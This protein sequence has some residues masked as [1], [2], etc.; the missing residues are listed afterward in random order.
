MLRD[1]VKSDLCMQ[2][3][4]ELDSCGYVEPV[5]PRSDLTFAQK[6]EMIRNHRSHWEHSEKV[7]P[8]VFELGV[9][10]DSVI[11]K[12]AG[13]VYVQELP[14]ANLVG[15]TRGLNFNQLPSPNRGIEYKHWAIPDLGSDP[16]DFCIDPEQDLLVLLEAEQGHWYGGTY[17]LHLR[18]MSTNEVHP[19][20]PAGYSILIH[21]HPSDLPPAMTFYFEVSGRLL[22]VLFRSVDRRVQSYVVVWDWTTGLELSVSDIL[23]S[24]HIS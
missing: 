19:K 5:N 12:Y 3:L 7:I 4:L 18:T 24:R 10:N 20:A 17:R 11:Y 14:T 9:G 6:L 16:S 8:T 23:T 15:S 13:G 21:Q 1:L 2:Y 22:A